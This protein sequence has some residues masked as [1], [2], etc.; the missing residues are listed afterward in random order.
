MDVKNNPFPSSSLPSLLFPPP[1]SLSP[2]SSFF[3][4]SNYNNNKKIK[5]IKDSY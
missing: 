4:D 3:Y 2:P 5:F 1:F